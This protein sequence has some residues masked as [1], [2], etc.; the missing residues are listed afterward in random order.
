MLKK[1]CSLPVRDR[2]DE[3]S[4]ADLRGIPGGC[5]E[6]ARRMNEDDGIAEVLLQ[7]TDGG[8]AGLPLGNCKAQ[9]EQKGTGLKTY[10][11]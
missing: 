1:C 10:L 4:R 3:L 11:R 7:Y 9:K 5:M 6:E 2:I 8:L